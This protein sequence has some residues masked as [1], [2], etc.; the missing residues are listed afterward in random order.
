MAGLAALMFLLDG[1]TYFPVMFV[2]NR[3]FILSLFL[4]LMCLY[5]H[6]QWRRAKSGSAPVCS[7]LFLALSLFANEG[8]A[9]TF[10]FILAYALVLEPGSFRR[11]ALT[12]LPSIVV[13]VLWQVIYK[14]LRFGVFQVGGYIDPANEPLQFA[15]EVG[16][17]A[18][19]LLGGQLTSL[20]PDLLLGIKP[21]LQ[22]LVFG[23]CCVSVLAALGVLLPW[24]RRD[25]SAA[26]WFAVM[27]LAA[28]PAATVV[29]LGK[30]LGFVA[31]G[32]FGLIASFV[33]GLI[34][35]QSRLPASPIYRVLAWTACVLLI[36]AHVPGAVAGRV[37]TVK[38]VPFF[39][40]TMT[41][42]IDLGDWPKLENK[43]VIVVNAPCQY[44]LSIAPFYR[45]YHRQAL[46][47]TMRTLVPGCTGF[48]VA[49]GDDRTL[50]I[51]SKGPD[52]FSCDNVGRVHVAYVFRTF[53]LSVGEPKCKKGDRYDLGGLT[54]D[55]LELDASDLPSKVAFRFD[56]SPDSPDFHWLRFDWQTFSYQPFKI[57]ATG[58]SVTLAGP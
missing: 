25:R 30:N 20:S 48:D 47:K 13:I 33:G 6:H 40:E 29:P 54:V 7:A 31:V 50:V 4:G 23:L 42:L 28:I 2:A 38:V 14:R 52:I 58:Q 15:R 11:R 34:T 3:G 46:P 17:R 45:A 51:E 44:G 18:M 56:T 35:G 43:N 19:V 55:V 39:V 12:V 5:E 57:P 27:M 22:P 37:V 1:N 21:S 9:S 8:G 10:A 32:A 26:F 16:P 53:N 41:R 24:V 36:A 49:R